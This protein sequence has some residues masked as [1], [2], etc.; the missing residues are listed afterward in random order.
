MARPYLFVIPVWFVIVQIVI[1][2]ECVAKSR[3]IFDSRK[4]AAGIKVS[5][6]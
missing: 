3:V 2:K 6:S 5:L 4:N 1:K